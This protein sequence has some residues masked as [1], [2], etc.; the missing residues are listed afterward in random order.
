M[1][2]AH[3]LFEDVYFKHDRQY[4]E[5]LNTLNTY[6]SLPALG[7]HKPVEM[8]NQVDLGEAIREIIRQ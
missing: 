8:L 6:Q 3:D 5:L 1:T 4:A 2:P 7:V